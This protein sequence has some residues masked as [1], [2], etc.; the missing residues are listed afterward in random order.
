MNRF[1]SAFVVSILLSTPALATHL[2]VPEVG[3]E[4]REKVWIC[5]S[6]ED[7]KLWYSTAAFKAEGQSSEVWN[8]HMKKV[9]AEKRCIFRS[10]TYKVSKVIEIKIAPL[11]TREGWDKDVKFYLL[12][13]VGPRSGKTYYLA[14][15]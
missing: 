10:I 7:A 8:A 15:N 5:N 9:V 6:I 4:R 2:G 11:A 13:I 14:T 3:Q 12:E 1:L